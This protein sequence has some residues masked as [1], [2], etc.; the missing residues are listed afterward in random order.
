MKIKNYQKFLEEISIFGNPA[1]PGEGEEKGK[2]SS[3]LGDELKS[4]RSELGLTGAQ[5]IP[6]LGGKL[7]S[8][9]RMA[10]EWTKDSETRKKLISLAKS[11]L[12]K[13]YGRIINKFNI[14][15][16][17]DFINPTEVPSFMEDLDSRRDFEAEMDFAES[18]SDELEEELSNLLSGESVEMPTS[19]SEEKT[20]EPE[21]ETH[22]RKIAN[23]LIQG[24]A[25]N[26]KHILHSEEIKTGLQ[27]IYGEKWKTI[28]DVWDEITK[29][30]DKLDLLIQPKDRATQMTSNDSGFAG[31]SG[32]DWE[33][34]ESEGGE[35]A[36]TEEDFGDI[37]GDV[38]LESMFDDEGSWGEEK[39]KP[40]KWKPILVARGVDFPMI[41]HESIKG[42][43][44][45]LSLGGIPTDKDLAKKVTSETGMMD[46]PEDWK[47]G[48]MIAK[49]FRKFISE[50]DKVNDY[51]NV[52]EELFKV[53]IDKDTMSTTEF[54]KVFRGILLDLE[55]S[56]EKLKMLVSTK[57]MTQSEA[58]DKMREF[59]RMKNNARRKVDELIDQIVEDIESWE[60]Y[61]DELE[62]Y[63]RKMKEYESE[64]EEYNMKMAKWEEQ[65]KGKESQ[66]EEESDES[67]TESEIDY[68]KLGKK[69]LEKLMNKALEDGDFE[70]LGKIKP[71][72]K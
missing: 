48:P 54:M 39:S 11:V 3:Y 9:S 70:T 24:E 49:S 15:L 32:I 34:M 42:L 6:E 69:D 60:R 17:I 45:F 66:P 35:M 26:I 16:D 68:S 71:Y 59:K 29:I 57:K 21:I 25:K 50:N 23:L 62:E 63:N 53:L 72:L 40:K 61:Y 51:E 5:S 47:Y 56:E 33:E 46:E 20:T 22:K 14:E 43:W 4:K 1:I 44:E 31:A 10:K 38:D 28:F 13:Y 41:L 19:S 30:A 36:E 37:E 58:D 18:E 55:K 67:Q 8:L 27:R 12:N 2:E 64:L 52:R 7:N 65:Q